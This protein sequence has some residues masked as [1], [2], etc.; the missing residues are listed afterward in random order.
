MN[1]ARHINVE[2]IKPIAFSHCLV[3]LATWHGQSGKAPEFQRT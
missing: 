1:F 3:P 2:R